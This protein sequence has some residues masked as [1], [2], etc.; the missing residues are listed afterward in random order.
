MKTLV[1]YMSETGNTRKIAEAIFDG[2][3][4]EK[5]LK[6]IAEVASLAGYDLAFLGFPIQ[7][8]G[9]DKRAARL[10]ARHCVDGRPV[11]LFITHASPEDSPDLPSMLAKFRAA[12]RGAHLVGLFDCQGALAPGIKRMMSIMPS[13]RLRRWAREDSSQGQPDAS[14][15]ARARLFAHSVTESFAAATRG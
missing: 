10:L 1:A 6:P 5:E 7:Q 4:G 2:L 12:A 3:D 14:R 11:A 15:L 9:P 13:A 8:M